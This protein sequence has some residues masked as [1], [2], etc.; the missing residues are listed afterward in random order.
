[1]MAFEVSK[2]LVAG[3]AGPNYPAP[4]V[5]IECMQQAARMNRKEALEVEAAGFAKV[6]ATDVAVSLVGLFLSDQLIAKKAKAWQKKADKK[7]IL[8]FRFP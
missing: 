8:L 4:I 2:A 5:A 1:M 3:K 6:A 7:I